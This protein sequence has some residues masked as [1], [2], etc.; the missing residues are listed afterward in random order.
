MLELESQGPDNRGTATPNPHLSVIVSNR[1]IP[2][3][4]LLTKNTATPVAGRSR[5]A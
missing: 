3:D 1:A 4:D 2:Q 5:I